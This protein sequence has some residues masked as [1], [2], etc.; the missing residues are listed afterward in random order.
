MTKKEVTS[1][2]QKNGYADLIGQTN[3]CA[4]QR[5]P[6]AGKPHCGV[7]SQCIDRRFGILAGDLGAHDPQDKYACDLMIGDRGTGIDVVMAVNYVRLAHAFSDISLK[8]MKREFTSVFDAAPHYNDPDA[9]DKIHKMMQSHAK[10]VTGVIA[11]AVKEHGDALSEGIL[12]ERCLLSMSVTGAKV[13]PITAHVKDT[14]DDVKAFM[15]RLSSQPC[16]FAMDDKAQKV[17]FSGGLALQA[18]EY[19]LVKQLLPSFIDG[20]NNR[21][22]AK[23]ISAADLAKA[24]FNQNENS[25][26][27]AT[28]R[29]NEKVSQRVGVDMGAVIPDFI[30]NVH[31]QGYRINGAAKLLAS[32]ADLTPAVDEA[33]TS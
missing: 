15:D 20:K 31:G 29:I 2:L 32:A 19:Y 23:P 10:D 21:T 17:L 3:S 12:P 11:A 30:E 24:V 22:E 7:C 5:N 33:V 8:Q 25:F 13:V 1:L 16:E 6:T 26:R 28:K 9:L 18:N 4:N 14:T 27:Q